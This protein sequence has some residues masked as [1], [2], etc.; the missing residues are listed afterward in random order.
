MHAFSLNAKR[1]F[2]PSSFDCV[3]NHADW[4]FKE[5]IQIP[6]FQSVAFQH[7]S[8]AQVS[9]RV[10]A[11]QQYRLFPTTGVGGAEKYF[12]LVVCLQDEFIE[13][14]GEAQEAGVRCTPRFRSYKHRRTRSGTA[15]SQHGNRKPPGYADV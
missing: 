7:R 9:N 5:G 15:D 11:R 1:K 10:Q 14:F 3:E 12:S 13:R 6:D 8:R 2:Q 4:I